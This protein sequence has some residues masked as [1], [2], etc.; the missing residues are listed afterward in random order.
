MLLDIFVRIENLFKCLE[1]YAT[2]VIVKI[3]FEAPRRRLISDDR[4]R[5][6]IDHAL[7]KL[8]S[9]TVEEPRMAI[10]ENL[11]ALHS[12]VNKVRCSLRAGKKP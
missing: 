12:V 6:D 9:L 2:D 7:K 11:N 8:D 10:T 1:S 4:V 3:M 5:N